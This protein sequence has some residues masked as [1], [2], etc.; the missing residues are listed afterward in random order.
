MAFQAKALVRPLLVAGGLVCVGVGTVGVFVPLLPTAP[1]YLLAAAAF[2][3]SSTRFHRWFLSTKLY[4]DHLAGFVANRAM[5]M[6]TKLSI[7]LPVTAMLAVA[8]WLAPNWHVRVVIALVAAAK[9]YYFLARIKT[10]PA[11]DSARLDQAALGPRPPRQGPAGGSSV[12]A[13][14][15]G[16]DAVV[17]PPA[18][19][20]DPPVGGPGGAGS[21]SGLTGEFGFRVGPAVLDG[22]AVA[23]QA[24]DGRPG[25]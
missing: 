7:C 24:G 25:E 15:G 8:F 12:V 1:F 10:I 11:P 3:R 13:G 9:W 21:A 20:L 23:V 4:R 19:R 6:R 14:G 16:G 18:D 5:T 22:Y 2:A 17:A